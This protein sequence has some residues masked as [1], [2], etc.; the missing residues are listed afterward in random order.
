MKLYKHMASHVISSFSS[1]RSRPATPAS[2]STCQAVAQI[3]MAH[4]A[5]ADSLARCWHDDRRVDDGFVS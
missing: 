1:T 4:S 5:G 2:C 3:G